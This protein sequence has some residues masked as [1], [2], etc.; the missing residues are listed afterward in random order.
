MRVCDN[1]DRTALDDGRQTVGL[2]P[3]SYGEFL[4]R[5]PTLTNVVLG[6]P[7]QGGSLGVFVGFARLP[8]GRAEEAVPSPNTKL[9]RL[10]AE[11]ML[12]NAAMNEPLTAS[13]LQNSK[14]LSRRI[15]Q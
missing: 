10:L 7:A 11:T 5:W 4:P 12:D 8:A 15:E 3:G 9:M 1:S 13:S 14:K 6:H 2:V